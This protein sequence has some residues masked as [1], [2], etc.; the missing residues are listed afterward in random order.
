M[1][2][3]ILS[4]SPSVETDKS[5]EPAALVVSEDLTIVGK[6]RKKRFRLR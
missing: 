2:T 5:D 4:A 1:A 3:E 6:G